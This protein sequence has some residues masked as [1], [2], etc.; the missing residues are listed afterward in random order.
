MLHISHKV[1][2]SYPCNSLVYR[3]D[4]I[5]RTFGSGIHRYSRD[6][7]ECIMFTL[8]LCH[9]G[10]VLDFVTVYMLKAF[11]ILTTWVI[12]LYLLSTKA[13]ADYDCYHNRL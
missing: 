10:R 6:P 8:T 3:V 12:F 9:S 5:T 7:N 2:I 1:N 4:G 13:E 11:E